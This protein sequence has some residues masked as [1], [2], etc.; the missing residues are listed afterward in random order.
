MGKLHLD[1][2]LGKKR[3][4][5]RHLDI[6]LDNSVSDILHS[7][8]EVNRYMRRH[9]ISHLSISPT[10]GRYLQRKLTTPPIVVNFDWSQS[11]LRLL[12]QLS[13]ESWFHRLCKWFDRLLTKIGYWFFWKLTD[14]DISDSLNDAILDSQII[15]GRFKSKDLKFQMDP[16]SV[17]RFKEEK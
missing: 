6:G 1:L 15:T 5:R 4:S 3:Q 12:N 17:R 11:E 16:K 8:K 10:L 7:E 14:E 9:K 13:H 2:N